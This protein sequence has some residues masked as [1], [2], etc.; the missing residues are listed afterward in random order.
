V[1]TVG[2]DDTASAVGSGDVPVLA[3]PRLLALFEAATIAAVSTAGIAE[4]QTT[5]G[6]RVSLQHERPSAVGETVTVAATLREL[7]GR[8]LVF[9]VVATDDA[10]RVVGHAV[11]TRVRVDRQRFLS[12]V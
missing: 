5:V 9:D 8:L 3:T 7:D 4:D 6:T 12:R 11:V 1:H 10:D 2:P